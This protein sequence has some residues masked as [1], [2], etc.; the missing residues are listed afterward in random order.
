LLGIASEYQKRGHKRIGFNTDAPVIPGEELPLQATMGAHYGF[1]DSNAD[2]VR[3]LTIIPAVTAGI[4]KR[5]GSIEVGKD[6][7]LVIMTGDP[8]DPR[9]SIELVYIDG[10]R[11]YDTKKDVRRY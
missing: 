5:V 11:V 4:D 2:T 3:G 6:A 7:D 1:D 8:I 10:K 9:N